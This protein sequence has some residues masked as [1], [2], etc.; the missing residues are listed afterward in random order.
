MTNKKC[1]YYN[2]G[3]DITR[4]YTSYPAE[5]GARCEKYDEFFHKINDRIIPTCE[6]CN[7]KKETIE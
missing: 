5:Y 1:Y 3:G 4:G 6:G 7:Y 2:H